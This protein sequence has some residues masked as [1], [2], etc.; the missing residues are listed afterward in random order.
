MQFTLSIPSFTR[1]ILSFL[2]ELGTNFNFN[3]FIK[4]LW[5]SVIFTVVVVL[6]L[7]HF[8]QILSSQVILEDFHTVCT[9]LSAIT[10]V[11]ITNWWH[12]KRD[13]ELYDLLWAI[14]FYLNAIFSLPYN[15]EIKYLMPFPSHRST[16]LLLPSQS[17]W[18]PVWEEGFSSNANS[19]R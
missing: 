18:S 2:C 1:R 3:A 19:L 8:T 15:R 16:E 10:A 5:F 12:L 9:L 13:H 17:D 6:N 14:E 4:L 7:Y 11:D